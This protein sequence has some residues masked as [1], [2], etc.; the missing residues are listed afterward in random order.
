[1]PSP[2][3]DLYP[4]SGRLSGRQSFLVG[5]QYVNVWP[6]TYISLA[7]PISGLFRS[8]NHEELTNCPT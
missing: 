5:R 6:N 7:Q 1:M 2:D 8:N 4:S 3:R